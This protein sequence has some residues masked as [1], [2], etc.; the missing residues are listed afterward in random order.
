MKTTTTLVFA[1]LGAA[2]GLVSIACGPRNL[3]ALGNPGDFCTER[4][5]CTDGTV[6]R[7]ADDGYR[8]MGNAEAED[9]IT[10]SKASSSEPEPDPI[11]ED[12]GEKLGPLPETGSP[13]RPDE[14][15]D[16]DFTDREDEEAEEEEEEE[17]QK[18]YVPP[19]RRRRPGGQ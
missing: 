13:E 9:E 19:S 16:I 5:A 10:R 12:G 15:G 3:S 8:C 4:T 18:G 6:C 1:V 7:P 2:I 17:P 11:V 14:S